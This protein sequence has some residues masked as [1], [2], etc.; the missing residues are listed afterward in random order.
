MTYQNARKL[1]FLHIG[2]SVVLLQKD[3]GP[4]LSGT[5][6]G[7]AGCVCLSVWAFSLSCTLAL[8][9]LLFTCWLLRNAKLYAN[10]TLIQEPF[11]VVKGTCDKKLGGRERTKWE[12]K[13]NKTKVL[14]T[15]FLLT[16]QFIN[17]TLLLSW[18][19]KPKAKLI[20][21]NSDY[22][23]FK[24]KASYTPNALSHP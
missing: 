8:S 24:F 23:W 15:A 11:Y 19:V 6:P 7:V 2:N 18:K 10:S 3:E 13:K 1:F 4:L 22:V 12:R 9:L 16:N 14:F 5:C 21:N 20:I 17:E